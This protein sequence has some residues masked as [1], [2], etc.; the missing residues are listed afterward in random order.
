MP[1]RGIYPSQTKTSVSSQLS[2]HRVSG[3][4]LTH[5]GLRLGYERGWRSYEMVRTRR[6]GREFEHLLAGHGPLLWVCGPIPA[7]RMG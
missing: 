6:S 4:V 2:Q 3:H 5:P 1:R 7:I